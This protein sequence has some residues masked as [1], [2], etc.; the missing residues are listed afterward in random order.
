MPQFVE[1]LGLVGF[2]ACGGSMTKSS[3]L[4]SSYVGATRNELIHL[5]LV[6]WWVGLQEPLPLSADESEYSLSSEGEDAYDAFGS[7]SWV[8]I[9]YNMYKQDLVIIIR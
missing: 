7:H 1:A 5:L 2:F 3:I 4:S 8:D 9:F 6:H